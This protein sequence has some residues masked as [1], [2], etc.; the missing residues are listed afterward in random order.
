ML[1]RSEQHVPDT[2]NA[3]DA[4]TVSPAPSHANE[5][6]S[7]RLFLSKEIMICVGLKSGSVVVD[8]VELSDGRVPNSYITLNIQE[9]NSFVQRWSRISFALKTHEGG[10]FILQSG[11]V[12]AK[13][14]H[15]CGRM[16]LV[17]RTPVLHEQPDSDDT[18]CSDVSSEGGDATEIHIKASDLGTSFDNTLPLITKQC[19]LLCQEK[20]VIDLMFTCTAAWCKSLASIDY[21]RPE[22]KKHSNDAFD[23]A[24]SLAGL[25][26]L[27]ASILELFRREMN[28]RNM[29]TNLNHKALLKSCLYDPSVIKSHYV[30]SH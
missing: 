14:Y 18:V 9:W 3:S 27:D 6:V 22:A 12:T 30:I 17:F 15:S 5:A 10:V 24:M 23:R 13:T 8:I 21:L 28:R 2:Y 20:P 7:R 11:R 4:A 1:M 26:S 29:V 16:Y 25:Y 19:R